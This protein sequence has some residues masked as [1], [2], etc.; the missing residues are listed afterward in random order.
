MAFGKLMKINSRSMKRFEHQS[1]IKKGVFRVSLEKTQGKLLIIAG[2][3]SIILGIVGIVVPLLPTT[4]FILLAGFCFA[5]SSPRW[6][7]W[8]LAHPFLGSYIKAYTEKRGLSKN[9]KYQIALFSTIMLSMTVFFKP[10][11]MAKW[12]AALI[13]FGLMAFLISSHS[14]DAP[15]SKKHILK[16]IRH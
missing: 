7:R 12:I 2:F 5:R 11:P 10:I 15:V 4:P 14:A 16:K 6:H 1:E 3:V 9:Q 13:W 8:L